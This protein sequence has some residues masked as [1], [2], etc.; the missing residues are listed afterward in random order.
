MTATGKDSTNATGSTTFT[1]TI[2]SGPGGGT[3]LQNGVAKTGISGA[4]SSSQT[5]TLQVPAG[6]TGLKFVTKGGTGDAD[7][8]VKFGSAPTTTSFDCRSW[9][10]SNAETCNIATAQ[11]GTYYVVV[12]GYSAFSGLSLTGSFTP[13]STANVLTNGVPKTG[14]S[15]AAG[16]SRT[17]T[18]QVPAGATGLKFVTS[19]GTGDADLYVKFGS[20]P[21]TSSYDCRSIGSSNAETCNISTA[22]AGT[23]YVV[24]RGYTSFSGLSLTG[25]FS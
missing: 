1:W 6:A 17:Y 7:L 14:I 13:P 18:L 9:G 21:T 5:F 25:S 15:G 3:E 10:S 22:Q 16:V 12:R 4:A 8:Y 19:G 24:V 20:V 23:Y 11:G 2:T